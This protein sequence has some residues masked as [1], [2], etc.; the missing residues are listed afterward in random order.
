MQKRTRDIDAAELATR[1]LS[2]R[3]VKK[4]REIQKLAKLGKAR[5]KALACD[6]V[7]RGAAFEVLSHRKRLVQNRALE[8]YAKGRMYLSGILIRV[9]AVD[10]DHPAILFQLTAQNGYRGAFSRT[11]NP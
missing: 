2:K 7:K 8:D 9:K 3:A 11:V 10:P 1:K 4:I 6:P 5:Q